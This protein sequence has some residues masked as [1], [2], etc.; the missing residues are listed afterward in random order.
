MPAPRKFTDA[1]REALYRLH[2][3]GMSS[4][5]TAEAAEKGETGLAPFNI[6]PRTVRDIVGKM[7][8]EADRRLPTT[9]IEL[10]GAEA[11]ERAPARAARIVETELSRLERK[12]AGK[13]LTDK[14]IDRLPKLAAYGERIERILKRQG[15]QQKRR[16][17]AGQR[18]RSS[19]PQES[20]LE[21]L[22]REQAGEEDQPSPT[23]TCQTG[24]A[25]DSR[26]LL[27]DRQS[28]QQPTTPPT[29]D[30]I[31]AMARKTPAERGEAARKAQAALAL[32]PPG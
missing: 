29:D 20:A 23:R 2:A 15:Q 5:Q 4:R 11:M 25:A 22:T 9:V 28:D 12:Q 21:K 17:S 19:A 30:A 8:I 26:T 10:E 6:S 1:Q 14:E 31:Q 24:S 27:D 7:A 3:A 18:A 13:G 32:A 16:A